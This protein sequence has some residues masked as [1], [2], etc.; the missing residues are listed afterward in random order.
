MVFLLQE[1]LRLLLL[2]RRLLPVLIRTT[3]TL[4][5]YC[6]LLGEL[7]HLH[8]LMLMWR[9]LGATHPFFMLLPLHATTQTNLLL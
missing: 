5:S 8:L 9:Q 1:L 3:V 4:R 6:A 7:F 2:L